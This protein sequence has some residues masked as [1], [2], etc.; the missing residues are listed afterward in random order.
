MDGIYYEYHFP[1]VSFTEQNGIKITQK[2]N[3]SDNPKRINEHIDIVYLK[4]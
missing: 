3:S 2:L 1:V 4:K